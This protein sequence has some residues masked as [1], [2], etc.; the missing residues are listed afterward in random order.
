MLVGLP[1]SPS[2]FMCTMERIL[3]GS[4]QAN[5]LYIEDFLLY[6]YSLYHINCIKQAGQ[7]LQVQTLRFLA[8]FCRSTGG[9]KAMRQVHTWSYLQYSIIYRDKFAQVWTWKS[10]TLRNAC[11]L[12]AEASSIGSVAMLT[13]ANFLFLLAILHT[14]PGAEAKPGSRQNWCMQHSPAEAGFRN[15]V[16]PFK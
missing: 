16:N 2:S 3:I 12:S 7:A 9:I 15:T 4:L 14:C 6:I 8:S 11:L 13:D 5:I 10:S 1:A